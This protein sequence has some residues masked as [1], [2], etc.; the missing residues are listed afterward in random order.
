MRC[1]SH[2]GLQL[3]YAVC[4]HVMSG[5]AVEEVIPAER[6]KVGQILCG[7][8]SHHDVKQDGGPKIVCEGCARDRGWLK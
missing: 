5:A 3:A 1:D 6:T 8:D 7:S 4:P 2:D